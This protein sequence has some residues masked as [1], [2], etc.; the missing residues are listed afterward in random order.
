MGMQD[1][2]GPVVILEGCR[3]WIVRGDAYFPFKALARI[4]HQ[5]TFDIV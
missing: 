2:I 1:F 5:P 3:Q 4:R